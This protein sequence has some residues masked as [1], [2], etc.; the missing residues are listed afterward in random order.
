MN[1]RIYYLVN[2][3]NNRIRVSTAW[4]SCCCRCSSCWCCCSWCSRCWLFF[5][6]KII[7]WAHSEFLWYN[8]PF[9]RQESQENLQGR[10]FLLLFGVYNIHFLPYLFPMSSTKLHYNFYVLL[11]NWLYSRVHKN[12][13]Y[14]C[15]CRFLVL[16]CF[17]YQPYCESK[18]FTFTSQ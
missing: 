11:L 12:P 9:H 13:I 16:A 17:F 7:V 15:F 10:T 5:L 3:A 14:K 8:Q 4:R 6:N 18:I 1:L 2:W